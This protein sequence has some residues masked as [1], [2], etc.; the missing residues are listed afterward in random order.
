[1]INMAT[2][3]SNMK[4]GT[5][6]DKIDFLVQTLM[7]VKKNQESLKK[8]VESKIDKLRKDMKEDMDLRIRSFRDDLSLDI[9]REAK[10]MDEMLITIQSLSSR[11]EQLETSPLESVNGEHVQHD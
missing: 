11:V 4:P 7:E 10:R 5:D 1:M 3:G 2:G 6:S 8:M 9:G